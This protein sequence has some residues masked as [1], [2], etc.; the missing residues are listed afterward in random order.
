MGAEIWSGV[1]SEFSDFPN[2]ETW[3]RMTVR[4][5]FATLFGGLIGYERGRSGKAA[6]LRTHM[7]V[8]LGTAFVLAV[9]QQAGMQLMDMS[10][11]IQGV[12]AG[13]GFIGAGAIWKGHGKGDI[14]GLTTAASIWFT[15]AIGIA[16]GLGRETSA[17]LA[18]VFVLAVLRLTPN[19]RKKKD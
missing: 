2:I 9:P 4:L 5:L 7:L 18:V 15:A 14:E 11:V 6:G 17:L 10:R 19:V 3:V 12:M 16:V 13:V 1:V 8:C